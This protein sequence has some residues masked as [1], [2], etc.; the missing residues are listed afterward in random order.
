MNAPGAPRIVTCLAT[1]AVFLRNL[2]GRDRELARTGALAIGAGSLLWITGS[3]AELGGHRAVGLMATHTTPIQTT[4]SIAFTIDTIV[5]V[6]ALAAH[7][8]AARSFSRS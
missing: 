1:A 3:A 8:S 2:L 6:F 5:A 7:G 4:N